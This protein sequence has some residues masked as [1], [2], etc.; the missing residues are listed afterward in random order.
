MKPCSEP[1]SINSSP[2]PPSIGHTSPI[3]KPSSTLEGRVRAIAG[4]PA[5]DAAW[6]FFSSVPK[7]AAMAT[8]NISRKPLS[9][10]SMDVSS[11]QHPFQFILV[12][13]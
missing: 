4:R 3:Q 9:F 12:K 1:P 2:L 11:N 10:P 6:L 13:I 5:Q 7:I 8:E